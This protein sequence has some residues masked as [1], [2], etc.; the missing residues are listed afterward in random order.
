MPFVN[1]TRAI[2]R[3]AEFGFFG[4]IV[5]TRMQTPRFW[6]APL[7]RCKRFFSA[8]YVNR[9]AG[10]EVFFPAFLR[11]F[12]TSWFIVGKRS[13]NLRLVIPQSSLWNFVTAPRIRRR[14]R[15]TNIAHG[16]PRQP[17]SI[18]ARTASVKLFFRMVKMQDKRADR[19]P[20]NDQHHCRGD[21][22]IALGWGMDRRLPADRQ[23]LPAGTIALR[24]H[25]SKPAHSAIIAG[26]LLR[27]IPQEARPS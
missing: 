10:A 14:K 7:P 25:M 27:G 6:G 21:S 12:R 11:P 26:V 2:L 13:L 23:S 22:R 8:S 5:R 19:H 24:R 20:T 4:V 9:S 15:P 16:I 17:R 1:L 3:S 18:C